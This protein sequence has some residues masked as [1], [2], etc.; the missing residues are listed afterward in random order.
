MI[1]ILAVLLLVVALA[2]CQSA[3]NINVC[4]GC[5]DATKT[6]D[7]TCQVPNVNIGINNKSV[8][9]PVNTTVPLSTLGL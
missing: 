2:G 8:N 4:V 5:G 3:K 1:R 6:S 9:V 7:G